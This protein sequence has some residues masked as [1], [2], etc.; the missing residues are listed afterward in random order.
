MKSDSKDQLLKRLARLARQNT[1][2]ELLLKKLGRE[3][4]ALLNDNERYRVLLDKHKLHPDGGE[5]D[6]RSLKFNMVTVLF[7]DIHGFAKLIEDM[8]S[9]L[10]MDELD[11]ILFEFDRIAGKYHI[12]KIKTIGDTYMCA[13]GIPAKNITNPIDVVMAATEMRN[14]LD[15]Y[16]T[17][18]RGSDKVWELKIGIH[19]GPV[20]AALTGKKKMA[21]DIKG[22]T[23]NTASRIEAV[24][25]K[26][27][28]L[29]SVMTYELVKQY[30]DCEYHGKIPVKYQGDMEMYV[31]KRVKKKYSSD[32]DKGVRPNDI[33]RVKYLIRQFTDLQEIMLDKLERELP[34]YLFYHNYSKWNARTQICDFILSMTL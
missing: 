14:Y 19:T 15:S 2:L 7:A 32:R 5:E 22:E 21:Y 18:K 8:D 9:A 33:F 6:E 31:L 13:G 29:I 3:R 10:L 11:E 16:E 12:Q 1:E 34:K 27:T 28:I 24:S 25:E 26:G 23:V 30:F 20:T 4:D 17:D